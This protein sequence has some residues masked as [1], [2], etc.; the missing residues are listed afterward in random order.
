[1]KT[2][3]CKQLGGPCDLAHH[4]DSADEI[5]KAQDAHLKDEVAGGTPES[6]DSADSHGSV[7]AGATTADL[8]TAL[9]RDHPRLAVL[10]ERSAL[11]VNAEFAAADQQLQEGDEIA[12]L[13]PV[14]GG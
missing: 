14:S 11:A 13:P 12:L 5:I 2:M 10:L 1:M 8:R 4:G 3:T 9:A 6:P 7:T